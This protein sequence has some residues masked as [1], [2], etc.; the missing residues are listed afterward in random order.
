MRR[1]LRWSEVVVAVAVAALPFKA[2]GCGT[3]AC[4][5]VTPAQLVN[6]ACPGPAAALAR[7]SDPNCP[8]TISNV[9]GAGTLDG[10]FCCYPVDTQNDGEAIECGEGVGGGSFGV[11]VGGTSFSGGGFGGGTFGAGGFGG[12]TFSGGGGGFGVGTGGFGGAGGS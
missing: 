12:G 10:N 1:A 4:I 3:T 7:F 5:T 11:G 9:D 6:G 2:G 8:S